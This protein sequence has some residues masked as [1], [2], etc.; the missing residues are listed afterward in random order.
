LPLTIIAGKGAVGGNPGFIARD[1]TGRVFVVKFDRKENPEMQ[2]AA[3]VIVNR[4][5]WAAGY[6]VPSDTLFAFSRSDLSIE[7]GAEIED[8]LGRDQE[9]TNDEL[10]T[11]LA[12]APFR[13]DGSYRASASEFLSGSPVGGFPMEGR[14]RDDAN[15]VIAHEHRRELRGLRVLAAWLGH[16]DMKEDNTLDMWVNEGGRNFL[17][18]YLLDF[19]EA[20]GGHQAEK[21]RMEDG[22]EY[23]WDY[24]KQFRA[25][26]SFGFWRRP[27]EDQENTQWLSIGAFS[28]EYFDP[29]L[30][31][32]AYPYQPFHEADPSDLYW[33]AKL[34]M[35][36]DRDAI[37]AVVSEGAFSDDDAAD[38]LVEALL[39]RQRRIGETW[40]E[41]VSPIDAF[42]VVGR[43]LCAV[44]LGVY[45]GIADIGVVERLSD[46]F[47]PIFDAEDGNAERNVEE[48]P[49]DEGG[50][51][52]LPLGDEDYGVA[53]LRVRRGPEFRPV[54]QVHYA[55]GDAPRILG[56]VRVER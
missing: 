44:D 26:I 47:D 17:R 16:T 11:I 50:A 12:E 53:R 22:W 38:F 37:E 56:I 54:M 43:D 6:N 20:L 55:G 24:G 51:L 35:R 33:G 7:E 23:L 18:H 42:R 9:F 31:R 41:A 10:D 13:V 46:D 28:G 1:S 3:S 8:E 30:W 34:V 40:L 48:Y 49:V 45:Y 52:C 4:F 15:D 39:E 27:W 36:F 5:L 21:Q 25:L 14:R 2:T 19:G 29:A 32:E